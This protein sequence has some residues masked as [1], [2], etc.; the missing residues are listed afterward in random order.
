MSLNFYRHDD[1]GAVDHAHD[2]DHSANH[3]HG[4]RHG[5]GPI[6]ARRAGTDRGLP[7]HL[8]YNVVGQA[9]AAMPGVGSVHDLHVWYMSSERIALSTQL[10]I[11]TPQAWPQ[12]SA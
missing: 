7:E 1:Q 5:S 6:E 8:E 3:H 10:G 12:R 9:R 2:D 11:A 4:H